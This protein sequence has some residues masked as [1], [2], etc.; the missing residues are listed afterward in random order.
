MLLLRLESLHD[1]LVVHD[2][3]HDAVV[4]AGLAPFPE[5]DA[6]GPKTEA[7]EV[8]RPGHVPHRAELVL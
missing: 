3:V 2:D 8:S 1:P 4:D 6:V 7:A 5:L